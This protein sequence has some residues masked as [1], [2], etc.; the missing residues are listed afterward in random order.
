MWYVEHV[1]LLVEM[2]TEGE[3]QVGEQPDLI[4]WLP[5]DDVDY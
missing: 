4:L 3:M 5:I 1:N 2:L